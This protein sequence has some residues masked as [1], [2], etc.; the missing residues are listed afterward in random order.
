MRCFRSIGPCALVALALTASLSHPSD[1]RCDV[2]H[3]CGNGV[4]DLLW[5]E[6]CE[7]PGTAAC[8]AQ[9]RFIRTCGNGVIE[10]GEE[11]DGQDA[12]DAASC[13]LMRQVCCEFDDGTCS[14][15]TVL[16]GFEDYQFWKGCSYLLYANYSVGACEGELAC[17]DPS[18]PGCRI[19]SCRD[20]AVD[21]IEV[22][23]QRPDGTCGDD[24]V[25]TARE[26][27]SFGC[28]PFP[29]P[30]EGDIDR[31]MLGKC[32]TDGR[33]VPQSR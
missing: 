9:C 1:G 28:T 31:M 20:R 25:T 12:C 13:K 7:P 14:G 27:A 33:C 19:G 21:P 23:C 24:V 15:A 32:G 22:C 18:L 29:W 17:P 2:R 3:D 6:D 30:E 26:L 5:G 10:P 4:V 11:C 16:D 8:D